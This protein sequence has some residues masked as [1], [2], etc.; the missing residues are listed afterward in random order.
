VVKY[1]LSQIKES[2]YT[3]KDQK[4]LQSSKRH[5]IPL[6]KNLHSAKPLQGAK[7]HPI[8]LLKNQKLVVKVQRLVAFYY[9]LALLSHFYISI[10]RNNLFQQLK[11]LFWEM[12]PDA[13]FLE[14]PVIIKRLTQSQ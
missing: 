2:L 6:L 14:Q 3:P 7:R 9:F 13:R 11:Q 4:H 1:G 5:P 12:L 8:T 10:L